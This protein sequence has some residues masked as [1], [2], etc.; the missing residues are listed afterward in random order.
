MKLMGRRKDRMI[1]E[2]RWSAER[3]KWSSRRESEQ[4]HEDESWQEM[5]A[6]QT[7]YL[8]HACACESVKKCD[9]W[10][11]VFTELDC[12]SD[13]TS[14]PLLTIGFSVFGWVCWESIP[15]PA[16]SDPNPIMFVSRKSSE[17]V[18]VTQILSRI[19]SCLIEVKS[20]LLS[21]FGVNPIHRIWMFLT[22]FL[23]VP[24]K[25]LC[26]QV[27]FIWN[28]MFLVHWIH[29]R[30]EFRLSFAQVLS[31]WYQSWIHDGVKIGCTSYRMN[32]LE[33]IV[34]N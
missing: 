30:E 25:T 12:C 8:S 7:H 26:I 13:K 20:L 9:V 16:T 5:R 4:T 17:E 28:F 34:R 1:R 14:F 2:R 31:S 11:V 24:S 33:E 22:Y 3:G 21:K 19:W 15:T 6:R 27:N 32:V 10:G 23:L 18:E 29:R